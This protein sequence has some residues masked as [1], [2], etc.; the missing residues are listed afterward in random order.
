MYLAGVTIPYV[1][2]YHAENPEF[3]AKSD[4]F[5]VVIGPAFNLIRKIDRDTRRCKGSILI[6]VL[7]V[8]GLLAALVFQSQTL[9]RSRLV[10]H[11]TDLNL[12][13]L[14]AAMTDGIRQALQTLADDPTMMI[15]HPLDP[16]NRAIDIESPAG[17]STRVRMVE[18][19][20]RFDLNNLYVKAPDLS[21]RPV[22]DILSD[23]FT[24]CG[25]FESAGRIDSMID[26]IDPDSQ[27]FRERTFYQ[28]KDP[29]Y[30]PANYWL[31]GWSDLLHVEG[32][33]RAYF[34]ARQEGAGGQVFTAPF[35]DT[36]CIIPIARNRPVMININ[37]ASRVILVGVIGRLNSDIVDTMIASRKDNPISS[38]EP[39]IA[40]LDDEH[41]DA[42]R[43]YLGV[44]SSHFRVE[45]NA[46]H[47]G[48]ASRMEA[49]VQ[50]DS[51]G[52]ISVLRWVL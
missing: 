42:L 5:S 27:G 31:S 21:S 33:D 17:V 24:E 51:K 26:W 43:P 25:D 50:R 14:R 40:V 44:K 13:Q 16:W 11:S 41:A 37:F 39:F 3:R 48:H 6:L 1:H 8:M 52:E 22:Q 7:V 4:G 32:F 46:W 34:E 15:D 12:V 28:K 9:A 23:I 38:V 36:L 47:Q 18:L 45:A 35:F 49:I 2:A 20:G 10:D 29:A 30:L 19:N